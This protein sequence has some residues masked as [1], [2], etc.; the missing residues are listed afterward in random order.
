M[1]L[2]V[3]PLLLLTNTGAHAHVCCLLC[4]CAHL[5]ED[6][7]RVHICEEHREG[8]KG[9][10]VHALRALLDAHARGAPTVRGWGGGGKG[11]GRGGE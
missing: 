11:R 10:G 7:E 6:A 8:V 3:C 2:S 5:N 9:V 1:H 4:C